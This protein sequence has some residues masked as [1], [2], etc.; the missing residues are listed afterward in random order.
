MLPNS[1]TV[2]P[3]HRGTGLDDSLLRAYICSQTIINK[4]LIA[5]P[6]LA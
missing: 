6:E 1:T 3:P 4:Q 2:Q 5:L